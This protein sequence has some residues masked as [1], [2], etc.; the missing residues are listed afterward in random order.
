MQ[1][2]SSDHF[3]LR[4]RGCVFKTWSIKQYNLLSF[5]LQILGILLTIPANFSAF[6][7]SFCF[8]NELRLQLNAIGSRF[9]Q[10][11]LH[12]K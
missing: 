6:I 1:L 5:L 2:V 7:F 11:S 8:E 12:N 10:I 9:R 4:T 3:I